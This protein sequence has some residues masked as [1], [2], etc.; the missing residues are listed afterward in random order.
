MLKTYAQR[1]IGANFP[2]EVGVKIK[3]VSNPPPSLSLNNE[4]PYVSFLEGVASSSTTFRD[5]VSS[6]PN[7]SHLMTADQITFP[8]THMFAPEN[9][10]LE[11]DR[12][13]LGR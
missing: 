13:L 3:N 1:Q 4:S 12:F 2:R 5:Q 6:P 11:Y 7:V 8:K 9:G 10:W